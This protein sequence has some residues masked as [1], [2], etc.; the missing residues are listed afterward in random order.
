MYNCNE[1]IFCSIC[2]HFVLRYLGC[3][4]WRHLCWCRFNSVSCPLTNVL[5]VSKQK[6][7]VFLRPCDCLVSSVLSPLSIDSSLFGSML[8]ISIMAQPS[9]SIDL[10]NNN[11]FLFWQHRC[12]G[13]DKC[14][15]YKIEIVFLYLWL[16]FSLS[17]SVFLVL[18]IKVPACFM[19][20]NCGTFNIV[21]VFVFMI[22]L[23]RIMTYTS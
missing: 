10:I 18:E 17:L 9:Q 11:F 8:I 6:S 21:C 23:L 15:R 7:F 1:C 3:A 16:V 14:I 12:S 20:L 19:F 4:Q 13:D 22:I 2:L 5:F